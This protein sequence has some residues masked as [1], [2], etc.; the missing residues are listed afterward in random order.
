MREHIPLFCTIETHL[1]DGSGDV[2]VALCSD[3]M[4]QLADVPV[5][6]L[7]LLVADVGLI[8][9]LLLRA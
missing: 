6:V 3:D 4:L 7:R 9:F 5:L 1:H 2:I 8:V